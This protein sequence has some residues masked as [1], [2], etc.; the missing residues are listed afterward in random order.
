MRG[1]INP[2][3]YLPRECVEPPVV[4][5]PEEVEHYLRVVLRLGAGAEFVAFTAAGVEYR[6]RLVAEG[7]E[8]V[9]ELPRRGGPVV[10]V[11]LY[12]GLPKG[13]RWPLVIQKCTELGVTRIVPVITARTIVRLDAREV[14]GKR[15]RWQKIAVEAAEQSGGVAPPEVSEPVTWAEALALW[16]AS[17]QAGVL[18]DETLAGEQGHG[19]REALEGA[20][21]GRQVAVFVGPEGGLTPEEGQTGREAGLT[22]VS[23]GNRILRTETAAIV[24]CAL[25]AYELGG[26]G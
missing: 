20:R 15:E 8:I 5:L 4:R 23:L 22:A 18:L 21:E 26:L 6:A 12:Q 16:R 11:T 24:A 7:A 13:K 19:L 25:V 1:M 3:V 9:A 17:G 2:R 10:E 14:E